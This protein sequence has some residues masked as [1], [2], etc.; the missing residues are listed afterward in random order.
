M[1]RNRDAA[2]GWGTRL[3]RLRLW[4]NG[5]QRGCGVGLG[6]EVAAPS[7]LDEWLATGM[8]RWA[9]GRGCR[10]FASG[11]MARN[12]DAALC[13]GTRLPRLR[14]WANASQQGCVVVLG[15]KVAAPSPLGEWLATGMRS[16]SRL[17]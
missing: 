4:A 5:S 15:D 17:W 1:A 9:G 7:P 12:R 13:W 8:R 16:L 10:A 6:D 2:L 3:P 11:R 14:L